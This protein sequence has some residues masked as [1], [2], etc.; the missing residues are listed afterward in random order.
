MNQCKMIMAAFLLTGIC[1]SPLLAEELPPQIVNQHLREVLVVGTISNLEESTISITTNEG[2]GENCLIL[3]TQTV[4]LNNETGLSQ[5]I[6]DLA[7]G[8]KIAAYI[9]PISTR[10]LPPQSYTYVILTHIDKTEDLPT[11]MRLSEKTAENAWLNEAQDLIVTVNEKTSLIHSESGKKGTPDEL[12]SG[13][14]VLVYSKVLLMSYP[15][16]TTAEKIV[17]LPEEKQGWTQ[18]GDDWFYYERGVCSTNRWIPSSAGRWY[19]VK[20]NGQMAKNES[21]PDIG[22]FDELGVWKR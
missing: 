3:D 1:P 7:V 19:Y 8:D 17:I 15:G 21:L 18:V 16:Q 6:E 9:S 13:Y 5:P 20:E 10:S 11:F 12:K 4:I 2:Y 14:P 22:T